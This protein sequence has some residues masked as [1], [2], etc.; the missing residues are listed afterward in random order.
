MIDIA[1]ERVKI[2][3]RELIKVTADFFNLPYVQKF[4]K[5]NSYTE[6]TFPKIVMQ[7]SHGDHVVKLPDSA[8]LLGS[9]DT[10]NIEMFSIGTRL[11]CC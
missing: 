1:P 3:G 2:I 7:Q 8:T 5:E 6:E 10:C 9:S 11:L 4:M